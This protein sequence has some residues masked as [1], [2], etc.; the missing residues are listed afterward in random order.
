ML[1]YIYMRYTRYM[2]ISYKSKSNLLRNRQVTIVT[3]HNYAKIYGVERICI[4]TFGRRLVM[5]A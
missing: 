2:R 5:K 3:I 4:L 1:K